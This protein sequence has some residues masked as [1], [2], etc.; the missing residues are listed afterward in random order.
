MQKTQSKTSEPGLS[1]IKAYHRKV[2]ARDRETVA[3]ATCLA[4]AGVTV[5]Q[6]YQPSHMM[7]S[8]DTY[9]VL[10]LRALFRRHGA[11]ALRLALRCIVENGNPGELR[12]DVI[13]AVHTVIVLFPAWANDMPALVRAFAAVD[14]EDLRRRA[15][16]MPQGCRHQALTPM[17]AAIVAGELTMKEAA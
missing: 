1:A 11:A 8:G 12:A 4:S 6:N 15:R 16:S 2:Q 5:R 10:K 17:I 9:A 14:F 13:E 7:R 3:L